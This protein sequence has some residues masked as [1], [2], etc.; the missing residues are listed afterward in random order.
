MSK[1]YYMDT[2]FGSLLPMQKGKARKCF[3]N[4]NVEFKSID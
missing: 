1:S 3:E 4:L 2:H